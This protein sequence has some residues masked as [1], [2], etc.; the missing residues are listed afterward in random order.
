MA[1]DDEG[2]VLGAPISVQSLETVLEALTPMIENARVLA[3][4]V[5]RVAPSVG[6]R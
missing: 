3:S 1:V 2:A 6:Y 4:A 5:A